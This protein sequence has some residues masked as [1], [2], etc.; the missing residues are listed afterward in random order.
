MKSQIWVYY[1]HYRYISFIEQKQYP[2]KIQVPISSYIIR[3]ICSLYLLT[4]FLHDK[5]SIFPILI[6]IFKL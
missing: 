3:L 2:D 6:L 5:K 1:K 4:E